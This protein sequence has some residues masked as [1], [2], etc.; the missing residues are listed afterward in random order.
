[1]LHKHLELGAKLGFIANANVLLEI[2]VF[3]NE[4][5]HDYIPLSQRKIFVEVNRVL[6]FLLENIQTSKN[7]MVQNGWL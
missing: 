5:A 3:R 6:P 1:M 4:I 7:Y 2:R